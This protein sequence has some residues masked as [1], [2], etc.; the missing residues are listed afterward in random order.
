M[1][2]AI[3]PLPDLLVEPLVR[4]ALVEDLGRAGDVTA[5]ACLPAGIEITARFAARAE[6]RLAGLACARLALAAMDPQARFET[7]YAD[8]DDI[9]A[10]ATIAVVSGDARAIL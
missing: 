5:A 10:G 3:T 1:D 8:G 7:F 2:G 9:K 6:G 4:A